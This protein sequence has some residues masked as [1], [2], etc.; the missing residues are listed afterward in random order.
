MGKFPD[1]AICDPG[2]GSFLIFLYSKFIFVK[3]GLHFLS[4]SQ[5]LQSHLH[6]T[7][8]LTLL[9]LTLIKMTGKFLWNTRPY[10]VTTPKTSI[11]CTYYEFLFCQLQTNLNLSYKWRKFIYYCH[12]CNFKEN[13]NVIS[14]YSPRKF[15]HSVSFSCAPCNKSAS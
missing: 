2:K 4:L 8:H 12:I 11:P 1:F 10:G 3:M 14:L 13:K 9:T 5:C 15:S 6:M 7:W